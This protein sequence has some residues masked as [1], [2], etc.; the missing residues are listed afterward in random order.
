MQTAQ[1]NLESLRANPYPGRGICVGLDQSGHWVYQVYWIMGRSANSRNRIFVTNGGELRTAAAD[2]SRMKDPSLVIY[3]AMREL[4]ML[5][6]ATNG[7]QTDTIYNEVSIGHGTFCEALMTRMYEPD[8]PNFTPRIS[9]ITDLR[10]GVASEISIIRKSPWSDAAD[11][12]F[13][14]YRALPKGAGYTI[15]TYKGDGDPLPSF[16]GEP[17]LLPL[18]AGRARRRR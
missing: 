6:I 18:E 15:T 3:N 16:D 8:A 5:Y 13:F 1:K 7:D 10:G 17:Y 4:P 11:H 12:F 9:V 2:P 14:R